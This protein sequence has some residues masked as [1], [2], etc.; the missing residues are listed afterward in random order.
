M[1][2]VLLCYLSKSLW[3]LKSGLIF[4]SKLNHV[5]SNQ[6]PCIIWFLRESQLLSLY[7]TYD[8]NVKKETWYLFEA[9]PQMVEIS[10]DFFLF[11][12]RYQFKSPV[13]M[14]KL[15]NPFHRS[16]IWKVTS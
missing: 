16:Q 3:Q 4:Q 15:F 7:V 10:T 12:K 8:N 5:N 6:F 9:D 13:N 2:S 1:G 14:A 11:W